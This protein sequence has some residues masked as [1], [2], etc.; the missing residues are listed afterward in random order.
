MLIFL[1]T[2]KVSEA[3]GGAASEAGSV[4]AGDA[5]SK[6]A[7]DLGVECE[8]PGRIESKVVYSG[9]LEKETVALELLKMAPMSLACLFPLSK[10]DSVL[11][12][13][14]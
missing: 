12:R 7:G 11:D 1:T 3:V 10:V 2:G 13:P 9:W 14:Y 6:L 5:V 4:V 8:A